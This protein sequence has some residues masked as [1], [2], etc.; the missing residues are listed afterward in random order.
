MY[1][2]LCYASHR[3]V[4]TTS[5]AP[6]RLTVTTSTTRS[7][8]LVGAGLA[9]RLGALLDEHG[10]GR[11]R[12]VISSP[13]VWTHVGATLGDALGGVTPILLPDGEIGRAHV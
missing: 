10:I 2:A 1:I 8:I 5:P 11:R 7:T 6:V 13:R 12:F 4:T 3:P 9:G